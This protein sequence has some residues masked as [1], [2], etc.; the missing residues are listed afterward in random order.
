VK[1]IFLTTFLSL[2]SL[3]NALAGDGI[4]VQKTGDRWQT[5]TYSQI[6]LKLQFPLSWKADVD[7]QGRRWDLLAYPLVENPVTDVQYR[8]VISVIKLPEKEH[9]RIYSKGT[10]S[11]NWMVSQH[12][13]TSQ[14]TNELW[15]YTRRDIFGNGFGYFCSGRIKRIQ[16]RKPE[17][18]KSVEGNEEQ[19][20]AEVRRVLNSIEILSTNSVVK[21]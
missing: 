8:I 20:A 5:N 12:L 2:A 6:R 7:D 18:I 14:M 11:E 4:S 21:P 15:I 1:P 17:D 13:Q 10:N 3:L 19:L 9:L 16:N